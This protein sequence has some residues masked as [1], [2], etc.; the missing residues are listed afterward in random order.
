LIDE[1]RGLA[2]VNMVAYHLAYDLDGIMGFELPW[3]HGAAG[4]AWQTA[5]CVTFLLTAG[6]C[7]SYSR[8]PFARALKVGA[9]AA[10]IT[11]AT[12]LLYPSQ[13]IVFG[14]LHCMCVSML[15][16]AAFAK[17]LSRVGGIVGF[18][19]S[20]L[21]ALGT[22]RLM[23]GYV[24]LGAAAAKL[25]GWLYE[26]KWL[27]PLGFRD[28]GFR[29]ADYFP[30]FPYMF[31]FIAGGFTLRNRY[32]LN[33]AQKLPAWARREHIRPLAFLGRHSLLIYML[34]QPALLAALH[35]AQ[36]AAP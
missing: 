12:S 18:A 13:A 6:A 29:S 32:G 5:I 4:Q 10:A 8:R 14:I 26:T 15:V 16:R 3:F 11:A 24:G 20:A 25:P 31:V 33:G 22:W 28:A 34:H 30:L 7:T 36:L 27:F 1:I 9:C 17:P 23:Y 21:L 2:I 19:A 35:L